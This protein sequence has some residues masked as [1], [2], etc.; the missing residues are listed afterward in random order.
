GAV[1]NTAAL[2]AVT[3]TS[4]AEVTAG[5]TFNAASFTQAAG[6]VATTFADLVTLSGAFDF[7]GTALSIVGV[8]ANAVGGSMDVT[9][10][11]LFT[12]A[13]GANLTVG[14]VFLQDGAG[15]NSLG[16]NITS[17]ADGIFFTTGVTLTSDVLMTTGL[18]IGD[19]IV[20]ASTVTGTT[21]G[22][23]DLGLTAG[24]GDITFGLAVGGVRLGAIVIN[25][26]EN[27]TANAITAAS[28]T[29]A[30]GTFTTTF[31]GAQN[32]NTATGLNVVADTIVLNSTVTTTAAAGDITSDGAVNLTGA[33][34]ISTAGDV[35]TTGD[36][37]NYNSATTLTGGILVNST[38]GG[39]TGGTI[40]FVSTL[41]GTQTLE[42]TAGTTG[43]VVFTGGV[44]V[45]TA[46]LGAITINSAN[47]VTAAAIT[48]AS[49][50][51]TTGQGTTTFNGA[52]NYNTATGLNVVTDTIALNQ[53][54]TTLGNGIVTLNANN[55]GGVAAGT[56]TIAA[57][58]DI[59]SDGAVNLSGANG[60]STAGDV[61]TTGDLVNYLSATT[62]TG[63]ILV[64]TTVTAI[65]GAAITFAD[66]LVGPAFDLDL[67]AGSFGAITGTSVNI[68]NLTLTSAA[69]AAFTGAVTVND[70]I[71]TANNYTVSLTGSGNTFTQNVDFLNT[72]AVTLG[73]ATAD[74]FLF[75]GGLAAAISSPS[76]LIDFG[77]GGV[78][79]AANSTVNTTS[80]ATTGATISFGGTLDGTTA[81]TESLG[82][83][84]GLGNITFTGAVGNTAALGNVLVV[85]GATVSAAST[86]DAN[87]FT[88]NAGTVA[89]TFNGLLNLTGGPFDFIGQALT[90]N[91]VGA[92]AVAGFM[93]VTNAGQFTTANGANLTVGLDF[94]QTG[95][96]VNNLGGNI[97]STADGISFAT[98]VT[99]NNG[100]TMSTGAGAGDDIVFTSTLNGT[101]SLGLT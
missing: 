52:Q 91:G 14:T 31:N 58:G 89:T 10:S 4:A 65:I 62:L 30:A 32:Y 76:V 57:A 33:N 80:G 56:L 35:T 16:G 40:T 54:V 100:I 98:G 13:S 92:N 63:T 84:A 44:G 72:G 64:N 61:T 88:Q 78:T 26:A 55:L 77:T 9:N 41:D 15:V 43:N 68:N 73:N 85:S 6:S 45:T 28:L 79:L 59:T 24:R 94:S 27:V 67:T 70:L 25:S 46:Q 19:D 17:T 51:Q 47:D 18:L 21:T 60:I 53:S 66:T 8:G 82:L 49:L 23:E 86:F 11:G 38:I 97:A 34:G 5:S 22:A 36:L 83:T 71:T 75:N 42:L 39:A 99:L 90:I 81:G 93:Q 96:G 7:T 1:G 29:Q 2:G 101:Q 74:T 50:T 37:V 12:T 48:A 95:A 20:F 87:S 69:S 3:V